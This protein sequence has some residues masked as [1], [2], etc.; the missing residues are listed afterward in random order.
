MHEI[1]HSWSGNLVSCRDCR[2]FWLNEG[3][4]VKLERKILREMY[5]PGRE[6][7]DA[8][9]GRQALESFVNSVGEDHKYTSLVSKLQDEEDPDDYFSL[10]AYEKGYNLLLWLEHGLQI[11]GLGDLHGTYQFVACRVAMFKVILRLLTSNAL[12]SCT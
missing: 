11:E 10:V 3:F 2:H 5:G 1:S 4:T 12:T 6:G 7:L 8:V 9:A